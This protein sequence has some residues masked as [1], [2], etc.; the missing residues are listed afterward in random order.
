[1]QPKLRLSLAALFLGLILCG[2]LYAADLTTANNNRLPQGGAARHQEGQGPGPGGKVP[3]GQGGGTR[4]RR[5]PLD[6]GPGGEGGGEAAAPDVG[7]KCRAR[8]RSTAG[9]GW[10]RRLV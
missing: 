4:R 3:Q 6:A 10:R 8:G 7:A 2:P 1:M 5:R 9:E